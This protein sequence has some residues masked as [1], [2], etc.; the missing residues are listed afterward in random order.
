MCPTECHGQIPECHR[1]LWVSQTSLSVPTLAHTHP[2]LGAAPRGP[3]GTDISGRITRHGDSNSPKRPLG[4]PAVPSALGLPPSAGP[5]P[6]GWD[7]CVPRASCGSTEPWGWQ[8]GAPT[9]QGCGKNLEL[10]I[11]C[12][13]KSQQSHTRSCSTRRSRG[14]G[15]RAEPQVPLLSSRCSRWHLP[16]MGNSRGKDR[17][18]IPGGHIK[19][20]SEPG[21][22]GLHTR[23]PRAWFLGPLPGAVPRGRGA[24]AAPWGSSVI[25]PSRMISSAHLPEHEE[26]GTDSAPL[27]PHTVPAPGGREDKGFLI[28]LLSQACAAELASL[29]SPPS[30]V[31]VPPA[32]SPGDPCSHPCQREKNGHRQAEV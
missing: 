30:P 11:S 10:P 18:G 24:R 16:G 20:H 23:P 14:A 1:H 19:P 2:H 7:P 25:H 13:D 26:K 9:G 17:R 21:G 15:G 3:L 8:R 4:C 12:S 29:R 6:P 22:G 31:P 27:P 5:A 28:F 32:G